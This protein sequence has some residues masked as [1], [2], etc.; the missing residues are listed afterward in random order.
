MISLDT[1]DL[2]FS[3]QHLFFNKTW[4][5]SP[6]PFLLNELSK[7]QSIGK[8]VYSFYKVH[9]KL[10][11]KSKYNKSLLRNKDY[12]APW[13]SKFLDKGK[14]L[15]LTRDS[16]NKPLMPA[17]LR[18]DLLLTKNGWAL[19]E[20]DAVP[21]GIG[22][23]A[24]L[25]EV[26]TGQD[27]N[28]IE[29][30]WNVLASLIPEKSD[31]TVL[32]AVS[33]ESQTYRPEMEWIIKKWKARGKDAYCTHPNEL[34]VDKKG[35]FYKNRKIDVLYRFFELFDHAN[36]SCLNE[37]LKLEED[38]Y[39]KISPPVKPHQEEKL[40]LALWHHPLLKPYWRENMSL[41]DYQLLNEIIPDSWILNW[42]CLPAGAYWHS[43]VNF[44]D[45]WLDLAKV[46]QKNRQW[47]L[48]ISGFHETAW[49][50]RGV[51]LANDLNQK[52]WEKALLKSRAIYDSHFYILQDYKK[53]KLLNHPVY[54]KRQLHSDQFRL[55]LCPYYAS[56]PQ[57]SLY[58]GSLATLCPKD[59]KIIHGMQDAVLI[60]AL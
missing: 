37:I 13:V 44:L 2:A 31:P 10:Y 55:R 48:K 45:N 28:F 18:P 15:F 5:L 33:D 38:G 49:G 53:P 12:K 46:S 8:A 23:T 51:F 52:D 54:Y 1:L 34:R 41:D 11:Q 7:I 56:M 3:K 19:T 35:V 43:P 20:L 25:Y 21:G 36:I 30:F 39:L 58:L 6:C 50:S 26:Y 14:P 22:L 9:D 47:V 40:N 24:F 27:N 4:T 60:P 42:D 57:E 32:I 17:V 16:F 29:K 59:K